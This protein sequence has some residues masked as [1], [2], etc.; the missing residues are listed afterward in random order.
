MEKETIKIIAFYFSFLFPDRQH[1]ILGILTRYTHTGYIAIDSED[2]LNMN[3]LTD[4][5]AYQCFGIL[6]I[7]VHIFFSYDGSSFYVD[8]RS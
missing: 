6:D 1:S 5:V 8:C 7:L 2:L 4:P 3:L